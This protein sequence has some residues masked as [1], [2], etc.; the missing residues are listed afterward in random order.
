MPASPLVSQ[1]GPRVTQRSLHLL[2]T[3]PGRHWRTK[4]PAAGQHL[5][6]WT[7]PRWESERWPHRHFCRPSC[8]GG[9]LEGCLEGPEPRGGAPSD[10]PQYGAQCSDISVYILRKVLYFISYILYMCIS[11]KLKEFKF[12]NRI[13]MNTYRNLRAGLLNE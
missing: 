6:C 11:F 12:K 2:P 3:R 9:T 5:H 1:G 8:M 7:P 4:R 13:K 10:L